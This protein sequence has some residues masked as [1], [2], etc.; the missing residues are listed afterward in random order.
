LV[1]VPKA[2]ALNADEVNTCSRNLDQWF[3]GLPDHLKYRSRLSLCFD[4]G[5]GVLM[6]H[7]SI[8]NLFYYA[9]VCA[10]HRPYPSPILRPLSA[11]ETCFQR[12]SI[13]AAD[14]SMSILSELQIHDLISFLPTQGI[15]FM[16]QAAITFLGDAKSLHTSSQSHSQQNLE[17]CLQILQC[18]RDVHSYSFWATNLLT[19]AARK[20][21]HRARVTN[22]SRTLIDGRPAS[23]DHCRPAPIVRHGIVPL[24]LSFSSDAEPPDASTDYDMLGASD[25]N[26]SAYNGYEEAL[27]S[28]EHGEWV[29]YPEWIDP[30]VLYDNPSSL[31]IFPDLEWLG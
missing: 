20:L 5:Q 16:M 17:A 18:L 25:A 8:L 2:P 27:P 9:L 1:L 12:K 19:T 15:T 23:E 10:L 31:D 21:H 4:P 28:Y 11:T 7:C 14:A 6:L 26:V 30:Y 29:E 22:A 24:S 3:R 13:H